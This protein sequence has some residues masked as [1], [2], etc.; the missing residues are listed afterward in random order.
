M[1]SVAGANLVVART[2]IK[3]TCKATDTARAVPLTRPTL[4]QLV[5][6]DNR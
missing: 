1:A 2:A 3:A 6:V 5:A 4:H